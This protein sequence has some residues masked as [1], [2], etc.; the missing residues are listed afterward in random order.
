MKY[1]DVVSFNIYRRDLSEYQWWAREFD[2]PVIIGEFHSGALDRGPLSPG[3]VY[4][5][6]QKER[7]EVYRR[8]VTS[9]LEHPLVVGVHWHQFSDQPTS[10]RF[11]G[12]NLQVGWTDV[13]DTPYAET[14]EAVRD[15]GKRMYEIRWGRNE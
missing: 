6:D 14:I 9:A 4:V 15:M 8:F 3:I 1:A 11:D 5:T 13:C 10:G 7:A 2:K 12:E